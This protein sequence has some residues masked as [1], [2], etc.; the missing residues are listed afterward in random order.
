M[1]HNSLPG[2]HSLA[3]R[4]GRTHAV[5]AHA[6]P[7]N[8]VKRMST[9]NVYQIVDPNGLIRYVGITSQDPAKYWRGH[10]CAFLSGSK[11]LLHRGLKNEGHSTLDY[12]HFEIIESFKC[13]CRRTAMRTETFWIELRHAEGCPLLNEV[14][15]N[16]P[17]Q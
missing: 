4:S 2:H 10:Q 13:D 9:W 16:R 8:T 14:A 6:L 15:A 17:L 11:K 1:I 12:F 3:L 7:M 5:G